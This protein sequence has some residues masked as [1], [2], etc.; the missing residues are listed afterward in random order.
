MQT[1]KVRISFPIKFILGAVCCCLWCGDTINFVTSFFHYLK[2]IVCIFLYFL[3]IQ[4]TRVSAQFI[5][6]SA[7]DYSEIF[8][9]LCINK[10]SSFNSSA[11]FNCFRLYFFVQCINV[12]KRFQIFFQLNVA[13][14]MCTS[15]SQN[16]KGPYGYLIFQIFL[17]HF[18]ARNL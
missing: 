11:V 6:L 13:T 15:I 8:C 14:Q 10:F 16:F 9:I 17:L 5:Y 18:L 2:S 4:T 1:L 3:S 7:N 12:S